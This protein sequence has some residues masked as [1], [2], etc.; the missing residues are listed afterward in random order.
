V[1]IRFKSVYYMWSLL[2]NDDTRFH[3]YLMC[4]LYRCVSHMIHANL[5]RSGYSSI[6][7]IDKI[8]CSH[9]AVTLKKMKFFRFYFWSSFWF[10]L[11]THSLVF[12][13]MIFVSINLI[14]VW[15]ELLFVMT[16]TELNS[17]SIHRIFVI[18]LRSYDWRRH[19]KS[20]INRF[21][22]VISSLTK[23]SYSDLESV[24]NII[25]KEK[26][27]KIRWIIDLMTECQNDDSETIKK[28][29]NTFSKT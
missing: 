9:T 15:H 23:Q 6:Y 1:M 4:D 14:S 12:R 16:S 19:I 28:K 29:K 22:D 17:S 18:S 8:F 26:I 27:F 10:I 7:L 11:S 3:C 20:I 5:M 24:N 21:S 2:L 25:D 13:S